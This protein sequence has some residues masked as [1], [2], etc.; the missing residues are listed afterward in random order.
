MFQEDYS[1][2]NFE[3]GERAAVRTGRTLPRLR[4]EMTAYKAALCSEHLLYA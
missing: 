4:A 3:D 2:S 1:S